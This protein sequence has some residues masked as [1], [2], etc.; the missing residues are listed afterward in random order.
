MKRDFNF[1]L[2]L[3]YNLYNIVSHIFVDIPKYNLSEMVHV[4]VD[5]FGHGRV[6]LLISG[7]LSIFLF[8][9][10]F[11]LLLIDGVSV[12]HHISFR[13]RINVAPQ[14]TVWLFQG[15]H[16]SE[17]F[18]HSN[19]KRFLAG[20]SNFLRNWRD[21]PNHRIDKNVFKMSSIC[22]H[23]EWISSTSPTIDSSIVIIIAKLIVIISPGT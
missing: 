2:Y 5:S 17:F 7:F 12:F 1:H 21:T 6:W 20:L 16:L 15:L 14:W 10:L 13:S 8:N 4:V 23:P 9:C 3:P 22:F 19:T 11:L 18:Q